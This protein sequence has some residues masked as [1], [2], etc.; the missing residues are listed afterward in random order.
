MM[1]R[2]LMFDMDGGAALPATRGG[3]P[4][5]VQARDFLRLIGEQDDADDQQRSAGSTVSR[6]PSAVQT[7]AIVSKRGLAPGRSAL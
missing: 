2:G 7:R 4:D 3:G 5:L 6:R 1:V